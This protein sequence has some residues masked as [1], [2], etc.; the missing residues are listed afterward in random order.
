MAAALPV[1]GGKMNVLSRLTKFLA[2]ILLLGAVT[3]QAADQSV[4]PL[5]PCRVSVF[6]AV[7][8]QAPFTPRLTASL[9]ADLASRIDTV[10][11][12]PWNVTVSAPPTALQRAMLFDFAALQAKDVP[13]TSPEPDKILLVTLSAMPG[14]MLVT[15]RDFDVRTRTLNT[16]V[17]RRVWQT[18]A[19]CDATLDAILTAFSPIARIDHIEVEGKEGIAIMRVKAGGLPTRD[20]NL[21]LIR[22][23]DI[24]RPVVRQNNRDSSFKQAVHARWSLC[25]VEKIAP[26]EVRA[27]IYTGMKGE[28]PSKGKGRAESLALRVIAHGGSTTVTLQTRVMPVKPFAGCDI[29]AYPPGKKDA[30]KLIGQTDRQGRLCVSS[31]KDSLM[32]VLLAKNGS[33]MLAKLPIV[34]GLEPLL[35][36]NVPSDDQRLQAEGF[37]NGLQEELFDLVARQRIFA[38]RIH[39]LIEAKNFDKAAELANGLRALPTAQEYIV[40]LGREHDRLATADT[41]I[42]KKIDMLFGDT[43]KLIDQNLDP[44]FIDELDRELRDAK[45]EQ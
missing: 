10:V 3:T 25:A 7:A 34:P 33:A 31:T 40:R 28:I 17:A 45:Q 9:L 30:V 4:W 18:S 35:V 41:T 14:G 39:A 8:P 15:A 2:A 26:E 27:R 6:V 22:A 16:P 38:A 43:R 32:C 44:H 13:L 36:A 23:G 12:T 21:H 24:F 42:Q 1:P 5:T 20:P 37:I 11:G 19:L 29:Y